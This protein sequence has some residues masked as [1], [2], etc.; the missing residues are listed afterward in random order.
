MKLHEYQA[1]KILENFNVAVPNGIV[2]NNMSDL[3]NVEKDLTYP[4]VV[5]A[6]V[7]SGARGKAG[8]I[9]IAN[10]FKEVNAYVKALLG[11]KLVTHQTG[12][13]GLPINTILLEEGIDIQ[14]ELYLAITIDG[15]VSNPIFISLSL[16]C[17]IAKA[18]IS[19]SPFDNFLI[20]SLSI[21]E[22]LSEARINIFF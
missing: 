11:E 6:Q 15:S 4:T 17:I 18:A 8:G 16:I 14:K 9:K 13:K 7:H 1:K 20:F 19:L 5:K 22:S 12:E 3:T 2:I 21:N 10:D